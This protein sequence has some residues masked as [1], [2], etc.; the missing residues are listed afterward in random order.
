MPENQTLLQKLEASA[1]SRNIEKYSRDSFRWYRE[2]AKT[3]SLKMSRDKIET[4]LIRQEKKITNPRVGDLLMYVYDAKHKDTMPYF[5]AFPLVI[6]VGPAKGGFYGLNLHYLSPQY[7]A[8]F[9]DRLLSITNNKRFDE[10]TRFRISYDFLMGSSRYKLFAPCFKHYLFS[11]VE[12]RIV[13]V[14]PSEWESAL[15]LPTA[16]FQK[17]SNSKVWSKSIL[18][19]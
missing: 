5:D 2:K 17:T 9:F 8:L 10:T 12:S 18:G 6:L 15:Y 16:N 19:L 4:T 3:T 7:R 1:R 13:K 14:Q 11:Q